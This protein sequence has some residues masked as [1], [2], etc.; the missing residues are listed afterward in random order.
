MEV[1]VIRSD[2]KNIST[3]FQ[4]YQYF[5][6]VTSA[7]SLSGEAVPEEKCIT[8]VGGKITT[9]LSVWHRK[10]KINRFPIR[11]QPAKLNATK[12]LPDL[13]FVF[14]EQCFTC[15]VA[16]NRPYRVWLKVSLCLFLV[17]KEEDGIGSVTYSVEK[18]LTSQTALSDRHQK[19]K[20]EPSSGSKP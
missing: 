15:Y 10:M 13:L 19:I 20:E 16:S 17:T 7:V 18:P 5:Y 2:F 11:W 9:L 6:A 12:T 1:S 3:F 14:S 8:P 4:K